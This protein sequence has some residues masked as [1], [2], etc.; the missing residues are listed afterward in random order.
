MMPRQPQSP[1][2]RRLAATL[3][4]L[5]ENT[6]RAAA[7]FGELHG[8]SQGK[9]SKI[10]N[11]RTVPSPEDVETWATSAGASE[12][13]TAE[14]IALAETV[15]TETR[16]WRGRRHGSLT[17]RNEAAGA[18][19]QEAELLRVFQPAVIPGLLQTA[20]YARQLMTLLRASDEGDIAAAV[21]VRMQRQDVLYR[22]KPFEFVLAESALRWQPGAADLMAPQYDRLLTI[23][24]LPNVDIYVLPFSNPAPVLCLS[25]YTIY[26]IPGD[27]Y[28]L[29]E[30]LHGE[31]H[32]RGDDV[33]SAYRE[34]FAQAKNAA[35]ADDD[36]LGL[37][38]QLQRSA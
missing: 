3:K 31:E 20:G 32:L 8:W 9:V 24:T 23:A 25:G 5:R 22:G 13:E 28:V 17:A 12:A 2:R 38:R 27:P 15:V 21:N 33:L 29:I 14:L 34:A 1:E 6:G 10:E 19:E 16:R 26:E 18:A 37:I 35:L 30:L 7:A 11:G 4:A 36:A